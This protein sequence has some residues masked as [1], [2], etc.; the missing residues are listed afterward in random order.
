MKTILLLED[1]P[2][3]RE[4]VVA[5]LL[6]KGEYFVL[7][8]GDQAEA[9]E[10]CQRQS[11]DID[12]LIADVIVGVQSGRDIANEL[13]TLCPALRLLFISG[14]P[15]ERLVA[16]GKLQS[17]DVCLQKP[18]TPNELLQRIA[19]I[20]NQPVPRWASGGENG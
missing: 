19:E 5:F 3:V 7:E 18:F 6:C 8:A 14:Y 16:N 17:G 1:N 15:P 2:V 12:L 9:V 4:S 11:G 10:R 13:M 20:L